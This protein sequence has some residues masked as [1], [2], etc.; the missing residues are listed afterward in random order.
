MNK[1]ISEIVITVM[2]LAVLAA[3][4]APVSASGNPGSGCPVE[5]QHYGQINGSIYSDYE[6]HMVYSG[7][8][9]N[10]GLLTRTFQ[11]VPSGIKIAKFYTGFW[12][13]SP[14]KGGVF[15]IE[16]KD[17]DDVVQHQTIDYQSCDPCSGGPCGCYPFAPQNDTTR[18]DSLRWAGNVPPNPDPLPDDIHGRITGCG[19]QFISLNVTPYITPGDNTITVRMWSD[20]DACPGWDRTY[21]TALLVVYENTSMPMMTYFIDEGAA[22]I[23]SGSGCDGCGNSPDASFYFNGS[24]LADSTNMTYEV[25]GWPHVLKACTDDDPNAYTELNGNDIGCPDY[26]QPGYY[27]MYLRYDDVPV[28][29]MN[30]T[31]TTNLMEYHSPTGIY[32]RGNVAWL[33]VS[34]PGVNLVPDGFEFPAAMRLEKDHTVNVTV[35]NRGNVAAGAFNVCLYV[36]GVPNGTERVT[37]LA[38]GA[39]TTVSFTVNLPYDCY[40]FKAVVDC[41]SEV[42]EL[43]E[44]DNEATED[45]QVGYV[46]VVDGNSGFDALLD[47]VTNGDLPA[48]SVVNVGGTYYIQNLDIENCAGHGIQIENT[49]VPFVIHDCRVHDCSSGSSTTSA[50]YLHNLVDGKVNDS[51]LED[52]QTGMRLQNCSHVDI[53]NNTVQNNNAYGIDVYM[54]TMPTVDSE[55]INITGNRVI[56]GSFC[57]ELLGDNCIVRDNTMRDSTNSDYAVYVFGNDSKI[58]NNIIRDNAGYGLKLL[59][60]PETP[61]LRNYVYWNNFT[62]NKGGATPQGYDSGTTN[63]W[64]SPKCGGYPYGAVYTNYT[65]NYWDD[66]TAP[67]NNGDGIVDT[68]YALDGGAGA[69]DS[70]P[71][72]TLPWT[73]DIPI[74]SGKNLIAIPLIQDDPTLAAVFGDNPVNWD[75]V[76]RYIPGV[77]YKYSQYYNGVWYDAV[78]VEPIEPEVGYE[79]ERKG[80]DYTLTIVGTRY[81]GTISTP[82]YNGK[83][84]IGY[85]NFTNTGLSTFNSPVNWDKVWRYIPGVGYKYSQYYNGVWYDAVDVEP[86][87]VGVGYEYERKGTQYDWIYE[88]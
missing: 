9:E 71:L 41:D 82:I 86:I 47:E 15:N 5:L 29:Y 34:G 74:Y 83:N 59:D 87:E 61:C 49:N 1:F 38:G 53:D 45:Y 77:G 56:G 23:E 80:A 19:V 27:G 52:S 18:C 40:E 66:H 12:Q 69:E 20:W 62:N 85:V 78:D 55:F 8:P 3:F 76:W 57:M 67:D 30:Q 39:D 54:G 4:S 65:G 35:K 11:N 24:I 46:I 72:V 21:I 25:L 17:G 79:Y 7:T 10:P 64:N 88:A 22:Y 6:T 51:T 37:G 81:T 28:S 70:Y 48:G 43:D 16:I 75:K 73:F 44:S 68:A 36:D 33:K 31:G 2:V 13:G 63:I 58:C 14:G 60:A 32:M 84:L 50:V 42:M 26:E